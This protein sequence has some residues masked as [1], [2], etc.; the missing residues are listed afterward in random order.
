[1]DKFF[2]NINI[3]ANIKHIK[4][5]IGLGLCN[6]YSQ[7]WL[8][9]ESNLFVFMFDPN[10]DS[11]NSSFNYT[12][13]LIDIINK[14]NNRYLIIPVAL[15]NVENE[16]ILDFYSMSRDGGTSSLY[17]PDDT[18]LGPIKSINKVSVF[19]L[20]N[21]FDLFPWDRFQ[22]IEY[23]KIDAQGA[24]LDI[25]KSAGKY[26]S[27]RVVFLTAEPENTIYNNCVDNTVEN[28]VKYLNEQGFT[29]INH[30][31]TQDPT[32]INNKFKHL[33]DNIYINQK[34]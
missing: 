22:Y 3:P 4:I 7:N 12:N 21:F 30:H 23:I 20:K 26:L 27:E 32:F 2:E 8:K 6:I 34:I 13:Q 25:I 24:D 31:N 17:K 33:Y 16:T 11:I 5:D 10:I 1:M 15:S 29:K 9:N 19:S 28:M 14:N 18:I